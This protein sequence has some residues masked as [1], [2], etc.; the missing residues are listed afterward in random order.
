[1]GGFSEWTRAKDPGKL[2]AAIET[3]ITAQA[4]YV[5][6]RDGVVAHLE[7]GVQASDLY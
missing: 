5:V 7:R 6:W 4:E 2:S 1:M 3:K